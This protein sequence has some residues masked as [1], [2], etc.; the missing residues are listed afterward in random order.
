M[1]IYRE[2]AIDSLISCLRQTDFP[3]A[4]ITAAET[5]MSLQ[6]RFTISGKSLTRASLLKRAGLEKSYKSLVRMDQ[7]SNLSAEGK[8][9][10]V[11]RFLEYIVL[12]FLLTILSSSSSC[13]FLSFCGIYHFLIFFLLIN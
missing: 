13:L 1:S 4:Q 7:L 6:G 3:T 2:E 10:F 9:T 8:K 12:H 5:I 11:V